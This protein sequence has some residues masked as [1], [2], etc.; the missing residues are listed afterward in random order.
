[1]IYAIWNVQYQGYRPEGMQPWWDD[2]PSKHGGIF[3][4]KRFASKQDADRARYLE[5]DIVHVMD[6]KTCRIV[7][8][9]GDP[10]DFA[11]ADPMYRNKE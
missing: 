3:A 5:G 4:A 9:V 7:E 2:K 11:R 6:E 8:I 1:M 10:L